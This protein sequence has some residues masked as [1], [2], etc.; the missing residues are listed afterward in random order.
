MNTL[1][2]SREEKTNCGS[3]RLHTEMQSKVKYNNCCLVSDALQ[4]GL[5]AARELAS[6]PTKQKRRRQQDDTGEGGSGL[7]RRELEQSQAN[8]AKRAGGAAKAAE[9]LA[10]RD[11]EKE[12]R[13]NYKIPR[14]AAAEAEGAPADKRQKTADKGKKGRDEKDKKKKKEDREKKQK[15]AKK[16]KKKTK[17]QT[18]SESE[19]SSAEEQ[20]SSSSSSSDNDTSSDPSSEESSEDD[21]RKKRKKSG[22]RRMMS[23][24]DWETGVGIWAIEDRPTGLQL[25]TGSAGRMTLEKL[26]EIGK[27]LQPKNIDTLT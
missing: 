12:R 5:A 14:R 27:Y 19:S 21:S 7:S 6:R 18:S 20:Q 11:R 15:K 23:K 8:T 16:A 10:E 13:A 4:A 25:R 17:K 9:E 24:E 3:D 22:R 2:L 26:L 1:T